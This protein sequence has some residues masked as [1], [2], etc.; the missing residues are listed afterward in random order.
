M[1]L[2]SSRG[3]DLSLGCAAEALREEQYA[4]N[5]EEL[6]PYFSLPRVLQV[7]GVLGA[8]MMDQT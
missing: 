5:Q 4:F 6:R 2:R 8:L 1:P 3:F 7:H